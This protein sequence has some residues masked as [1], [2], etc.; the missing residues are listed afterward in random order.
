MAVGPTTEKPTTPVRRSSDTDDDDATLASPPQ[1]SKK[2]RAFYLSFLAIMVATF[3]SALDLTAVATALPTIARALDDTHGDFTWIGSAYALA[4]TAFIPLSANLSH[5]FGRK[6]IFLAAVTIFAVGSAIAGEFC[7][8][9]MLIAG[10]GVQGIGGGGILA[11]AE[12]LTADLVPLSERGLYRG[13][14]GL[15]WSFASVIGPPVGGALAN[16]SDKGWRWL[17]CEYLNLPVSSLAFVLI[18]VFLNV[19]RPEG[20]IKKKLRTIDWIGNILV[21]FGSGLAIVGLTWGGIR[22]SWSSINVLAPLLLGFTLLFGFGVYEARGPANPTI[23]LDIIGNRTSLSGLIATASHAICSITAIYFM[24]V[25][26]QAC[27]GATPLQSAVDFLPGSGFSAPTAL[28]AG[29]AIKITQRYRLANWVGWVIMIVGAGLLSLL[30]DDS[31]KGDWVGFQILF[32]TGMGVL[33][34]API[35][36][37]LAPL[38]IDRAPSAIALFTFTRAFF[39]AWG[40]TIASTILQNKLETNLPIAFLAEFPQGYEIAYAAIPVISKLE[41]PLKGAVQAGFA[42]SLSTMWKVMVGIA[43]V[44]FLASLFMKEIPLATVVDEKYALADPERS[45]EESR[46]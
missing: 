12:I 27:L 28:I 44:G 42:A 24:P 32:S 16:G 39:Q 3:L 46:V 11:L 7:L 17:F 41:Q 22:Y 31:P 40:I 13:L 23:P 25:Y 34:T 36:P 5:A 2:S 35:F 18:C 43:V 29:A 6:P 15:V 38:P 9:P 10:R 8:Q 26:L 33:F 19:R 45:S 21:L 30:K 37:V 14:L 20:S 1:T 4:S